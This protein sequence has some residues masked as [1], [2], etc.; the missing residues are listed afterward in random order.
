[1][2]HTRSKLQDAQDSGQYV[3]WLAKAAKKEEKKPSL[4]NKIVKEL[5]ELKKLEPEERFD[6]LNK[7]VHYYSKAN[8]CFQETLIGLHKLCPDDLIKNGCYDS[9]L[10]ADS[11]LE[12]VRRYELKIIAPIAKQIRR[13]L[14]T[15]FPN[16]NILFLGRDFTSVYLTTCG[17]AESPTENASCNQRF[18]MANIS[19]DVRDAACS[20]KIGELALFLKR[21]GLSKDALVEKGLVITDAGK[22][23]KI[24][25]I[26]FKALTLDMSASEAYRF[27]THC[28]VRY[29][30]SS[31]T[32]GTPL[33]GMALKIAID[34][35]LS[36]KDIDKLLGE[37]K[38]IPQGSNLEAIKEFKVDFSMNKIMSE[39]EK[40]SSLVMVERRHKLFE[41]RPKV[42]MLATGISANCDSKK[43][44]KPQLLSLSPAS[45]SERI[46]QT[47]GLYADITL[48]RQA[49]TERAMLEID[50]AAKIP[51]THGVVAETSLVLARM[52]VWQKRDYPEAHEA[53]KRMLIVDPP[54]MGF[55]P[56]LKGPSQPAAMLVVPGQLSLYGEIRYKFTGIAGEGRNIIA[57]VTDKNTI[58][59]VVKHSKNARKNL[60]LA[61]AEPLLFDYGFTPAKILEVGPYGLYVEQEYMPGDTLEQ[62]Y[63]T[64]GEDGELLPLPTGKLRDNILQEFKQAK[65]LI[66]E[67]GIW[68]DLKSANYH[69]GKVDKNLVNTDYVPRLNSSHY[70]YFTKVNGTP[71]SDDEFLDLFFYHSLHKY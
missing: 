58:V 52:R 20:G 54:A 50:V 13:Q 71:L 30:R 3:E 17:G 27:L 59:K 33:A 37:T 60:L 10:F 48:A 51:K 45:P 21:I 61:W 62:Q 18:F 23:G 12:A 67:R 69:C 4:R 36:E 64:P 26:V 31:N 55:L 46:S 39:I 14:Q 43:G 66:K 53:R 7:V 57:Y 35:K 41:W 15:E 65:K 22:R 34:E 25:A 56:K 11:L 2:S 44:A 47:L 70:R 42:A 5:N 9:N 68:L 24:P 6:E 32:K 49:A 28:H 40:A 19:R 38:D 16:S 1:M 29:M 8:K 63:N